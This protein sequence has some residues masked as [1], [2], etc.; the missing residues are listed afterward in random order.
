M[1]ALTVTELG[2]AGLHTDIEATVH[3]YTIHLGILRKPVRINHES[4][5]P[6]SLRRDVGHVYRHLG[7]CHSSGMEWS[8]LLISQPGTLLTSCKYIGQPALSRVPR[9]SHA[10]DEKSM[11]SRE[12]RKHGTRLSQQSLEAFYKSLGIRREGET[13]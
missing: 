2:P 13:G 5:A 4:S 6:G 8:S 12:V 1:I 11:E 7:A 10:A 3:R 9:V